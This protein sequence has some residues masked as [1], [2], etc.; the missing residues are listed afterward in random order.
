[1]K[2]EDEAGYFAALLPVRKVPE[3]K[4]RVKTGETVTESYDP[5]A[6]ACQITEEEEKAFCAGV[7]YEAYKK[8]GAHPMENQRNKKVHCLLSGL[9]MPS[10]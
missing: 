1:V 5:Y 7:Y 4:F 6:F 3:Y 10:A 9:R 8:L 2:K